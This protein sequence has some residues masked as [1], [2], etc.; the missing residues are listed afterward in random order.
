MELGKSNV[1]QRIHALS[2]RLRE[3]LHAMQHVHLHTPLSDEL[4]SGIVCFDVEG[5]APR[6][7]VAWLARKRIV[8]SESPYQPACARLAASVF[9]TE[10]EVEA[11]LR[12]VRELV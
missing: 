1:Q 3:G 5:K 12:A 11:A 7:V 10:E 9:N 4:A 6:Y 2:R 8:A